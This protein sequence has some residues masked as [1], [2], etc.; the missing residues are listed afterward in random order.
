LPGGDREAATKASTQA[1]E[2]LEDNPAEQSNAYVLRAV[3]R[4]DPEKKMEDLD[5]A[6]KLNSSNLKA[7]EARA[8]LRLQEED[9]EGAIEDLEAVLL[10]DPTNQDV[11]GAAVQRLVEMARVDDAIELITK[12]L[13]A[14]PSEGMYRMR[15]IL[16]RSLGKP[17][18]ALSDINKAISMQPRDPLS[19]IQRAQLALDRGDLKSAKQD[20]RSAQ[21][22]APQIVNLDQAIEVRSA[23]ALEENRL[24]DA[25]NDAMIL[26]E[27]NPDNLFR[28]LRLATLY[29]LDKRPRKAI[30]IF[31][32][33]IQDQ[34]NNAALLR[35][36]GDA[37]LSVGDHREAIDDYEKAIEAIGEVDPESASE[38]EKSEAAGIYNNLSWVLATSPKDEIRDGERALELGEKAAKLSD[39]AEPHILSTL[40]AAYAETGNFDK[41]IEWSQKAVE[42][43]AED[44]DQLDQLK[45]ELEAYKKRE[46]WREVQET[47]ENQVPILSPED[48]IDT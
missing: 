45:N 48:L 5:R 33:I 34:P 6:I 18:E 16:Y 23:I 17:D 12:M 32:D 24:A 31:D 38:R 22:I 36:R 25:I 42:L 46:P 19:L 37:L 35:S 20:F 26:V 41:A 13:A 39:Y 21:Q 9:V 47:E 43:G 7:L 14:K 30:E 40:A 27:R 28:Q 4:E 44:H 3:V 29:S 15:A 2:L 10:D 1:I 11:A 8:A